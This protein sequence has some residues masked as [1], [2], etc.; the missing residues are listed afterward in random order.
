MPRKKASPQVIERLRNKFLESLRDWRD[1]TEEVG[2]AYVAYIDADPTAPRKLATIQGLSQDL[3]RGFELIGR[4]KL[5]PELIMQIDMYDLPL[6][7]Q[8]R[9]VNGPV[10]V[11]TSVYRGRPNITKVNLQNARYQHRKRVIAKD[12][13]RTSEEQISLVKEQNKPK[14]NRL[15]YELADAYHVKIIRANTLLNYAQLTMLRSRIKK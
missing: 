14:K 9:I 7:D 6:K 5:L 4:K 3:L 15:L 10:E 8:E 2:D 11:V 1:H 12:H 13:L